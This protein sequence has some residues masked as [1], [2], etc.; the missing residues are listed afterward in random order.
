[1]ALKKG[2]IFSFPLVSDGQGGY[3]IVQDLPLSDFA[4][5]K[6]TATEDELKE[7]KAVVTD[8]LKG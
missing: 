7:E 3:A 8:L 5:E 4:R 2:L 1:M 6:L